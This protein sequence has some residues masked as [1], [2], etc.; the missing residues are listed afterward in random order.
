MHVPDASWKAVR[1]NCSFMCKRVVC[2]GAAQKQEQALPLPF[3]PSMQYRMEQHPAQHSSATWCIAEH[4]NGHSIGEEAGRI[5]AAES[6]HCVIWCW[7]KVSF[8]STHLRYT[9]HAQASG[10][11]RTFRPASSRCQHRRGCPMVL[12]RH[13]PGRACWR[14]ATWQPRSSWHCRWGACMVRW[15]QVMR[16]TGR[17]PHYSALLLRRA[18]HLPYGI[19]RA[20]ACTQSR[21]GAGVCPAC[22]GPSLSLVHI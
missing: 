3:A 11:G 8:N 22:F 2:A 17:F 5:P 21:S 9:A 15:W 19:W 14:R 13:S 7:A 6:W 12:P 18:W 1:Y 10:A 16:L 4:A 20:G